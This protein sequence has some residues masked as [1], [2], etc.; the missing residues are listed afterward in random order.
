MAL[1]NI[2]QS[3]EVCCAILLL[4]I[5]PVQAVLTDNTGATHPLETSDIS[6]KQQANLAKAGSGDTSLRKQLEQLSELTN[7]SL[8]E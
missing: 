4:G 7:S 1:H 5:I 3:L 6:D 2:R 8:C